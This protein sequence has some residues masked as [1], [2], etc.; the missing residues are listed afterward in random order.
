MFSISNVLEWLPVGL[1]VYRAQER[2]NE[3]KLRHQTEVGGQGI[4]GQL[5]INCFLTAQ[6]ALLALGIPNLPTKKKYRAQESQN[7]RKLRFQTEVGGRGV[8]GQSS[9]SA[10]QEET[11]ASGKTELP[12]TSTL[13]RSWWMGSW[14]TAL[15]YTEVGGRGVGGPFLVNVAQTALIPPGLIKQ[16]TGKGHRPQTRQND[17]K[18]RHQTE[19]AR[20]VGGPFFVNCAQK[21][22]ISPGLIKLSTGKGHR[23]QTRQN[24]LK[25]QH[26][27]EVAWEVGG[28]FFINVAQKAL[29]PP[30]L[31]KLSTGKEHR[32]QTRQNDLKLQHQT[33]VAWEVGGLF[34]VNCAQKA[35]ISPRLIKLSTGKGHRPQTRQNNL[36]LRHQ[37]EVAWEV[38]GPSIQ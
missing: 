16:S 15:C 9:Q 19:V 1:C 31:I 29:I 7:E 22:L 5:L 23:P 25:L 12:Q 33:E 17:L 30:G 13:D 2:Q 8:G 21:A 11:Q 18:L 35:L 27:T 3:L 28:P 38:G 10:N 20:E 36:K 34:F 37:T 6:R 24:D 32:P 14:W 26:R 4:G